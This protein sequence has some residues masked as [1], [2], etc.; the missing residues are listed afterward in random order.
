[1]NKPQIPGKSI[2]STIGFGWH[3]VPL[4]ERNNMFGTAFNDSDVD[5]ILAA[6]TYSNYPYGGDGYNNFRNYYIGKFITELKQDLGI[7]K[8]TDMFDCFYMFAAATHS[9]AFVNWAQPGTYDITVVGSLG[10]GLSQITFR[11]NVGFNNNDGSST[12]ALNTNFNPVLATNPNYGA[13]PQNMAVGSTASSF[14]TTGSFGCY[15]TPRNKA[16][17]GTSLYE[18]GACNTISTSG[19][20]SGT[21]FCS[22]AASLALSNQMVANVLTD[23]SAPS[24]AVAGPFQFQN[25]LWSV[26]RD[27][28]CD[29]AVY[30]NGELIVK[31]RSSTGAGNVAANPIWADRGPIT[32]LAPNVNQTGASVSIPANFASK[33]QMSFCYIGSDKIKPDIIAYRVQQY[34]DA[35][36]YNPTSG[37]AFVFNGVNPN[38]NW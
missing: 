31:L 36:G 16:A 9:D 2:Q 24:V 7:T 13:V 29:N 8:M 33:R 18:I 27:T 6:L 25:G 4:T 30:F 5:N 12:S 26:I 21:L 19:F 22:R 20:A 1:M 3:E 32:L 23:G 17:G 37:G 35:I 14:I 34:L 10:T 38:G 11:P 28:V 15:L